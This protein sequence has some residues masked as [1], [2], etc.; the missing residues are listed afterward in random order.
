MSII[1]VIPSSSKSLKYLTYITQIQYTSPAGHIVEARG[2]KVETKSQL[3]ETIYRM[4][5]LL[6]FWIRN[7]KPQ[8]TEA[9]WIG[10][11]RVD[12]RCIIK[13]RNQLYKIRPDLSGLP[14]L[15]YIDNIT[16]ES[17]LGIGTPDAITK[18]GEMIDYKSSVTIKLSKSRNVVDTHLLLLL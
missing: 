3:S 6:A 17:D 10:K 8:A 7:Y 13:L 9:F 15:E 2:P 12:G 14:E 5:D 4:P 16:G 1:D 11:S 18:G